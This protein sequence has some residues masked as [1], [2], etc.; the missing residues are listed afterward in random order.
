[1]NEAS[2]F[3]ARIIEIYRMSL[4]RARR[5]P[6]RVFWSRPFGI[7]FLSLVLVQKKE[8]SRFI[9]TKTRARRSDSDGEERENKRKRTPRS[10]RGAKF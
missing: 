2:F 7:E 1:M 8:R 10:L 6:A 5:P 9:Q 3:N 4:P